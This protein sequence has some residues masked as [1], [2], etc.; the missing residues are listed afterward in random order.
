LLL[1]A[2]LAGL[3]TAPPG[4]GAVV[5][6]AGLIV[7]EAEHYQSNRT[8]SG[9]SWILTNDVAGFVGTGAMRALPSGSVSLST[10][11]NSPE[12]TYAVQFTN[13]GTLKIWL[14]VWGASGAHDSMYV[15][16]DGRNPQNL[17][18]GLTGVWVWKSVQ[19]TVT[20]GLHWINVWMREDGAYVDRLLIAR[21]ST[22]T[23]TNTG[24]AETRP[25]GATF[26]WASES[27]RIYVESGGSATLT[28]IKNALPKAPLCLIDA[29]NRIWF[30]DASL[31]VSDGAK[32]VLHGSAAGGDVNE[33]RLRS[34]NST[35][36]GSCASLDADWGTLDLKGV[37][38]TS[39]DQLSVGPDTDY[40]NFNR[41]CIRARSRSTSE[42]ST[43][44][45]VNC[46]IAFLGTDSSDNYGL[47]WQV[48]GTAP[49]ATV[50]GGVSNSY[51]HNCRLGLESTLQSDIPWQAN[52]I[53]SNTFFGFDPTGGSTTGGNSFAVAYRYA[54]SSDRI[55]VTGP[56]NA[57][58]SDIKTAVPSAPLVL[59]DPVNKVWRLDTD[60][61][62]ENGARLKL[63]GPAIGG[64]VRE[65]RLKS[66]ST[67]ATNA[68]VE[69][70]ADWGWLDIRNTKI[71]SWDSRTNGPNTRTNFGRAFIHA[72][73]RLDPDGHTAHESR[74]DVL[75]SEIA[76][77]G[78]HATEAY[79]LTWKVVD[80]TAIYVPPGSGKTLFD[81]VNVYGDIM[82]SHIHHNFFGV[83]SYGHFGGHWAT[84]EVDHNFAYGF[85]PHDDS[86]NLVIENNHVHH[87]GWHGI[88]ASK[89]CDHGI[90]RNNITHDNGLDRTNPHG[91]GIML[92]RSSND[93]LV[94][95][96]QSYNNPDSGVA[97]FASDRTI[98]RNNLCR[99]N[100]NAGIR[101]SVGSDNNRV[102]GNQVLN[103]G[104]NGFFM[105]E[106][107]DPPEIDEGELLPSARCQQN[108]FTNNFVNVY[109]REAVKVQNA[110]L[111]VFAGNVFI[112]TA[113]I[114]RFE[115]ST[116]NAVAS[117]VLPSDTLA[118]LV[119][120]ITNTSPKF[121]S[122]TF[123]GQPRLILQVDPL[124]TGRFTDKSGAMFISILTN[125]PTFIYPTG[126]VA[127][128]TSAKV[129][130]GPGLVL[131]RNFFG[132]PNTGSAQI[133]IN[134]WNTGGN[135]RTKAWTVR[136][137]SAT[138]QITYRVGDLRP[139]TV[140]DVRRN[141]ARVLNVR[142]DGQGYI[143]FTSSPGATTPVNY[144]VQ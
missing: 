53:A 35:A 103:S 78:H 144:T 39:W 106:G 8:A 40:A 117:N 132:V 15:G 90:L 68:Y 71:T 3:S 102:E 7:M 44:S 23:P 140:Y 2:A 57:T 84:N 81:L 116:N 93:W 113:T 112:G 96:N 72:R 135:N 105:F 126:S 136:A 109:G 22:Y 67:R 125:V 75:N 30:L 77:L 61:F 33:L 32:L 63:Y 104:G 89:R 85:D 9:H 16:V 92:H 100:L 87:N 143:S 131:T 58:L 64:D 50:F 20:N 123:A 69:L 127:T 118:K 121:T 82:N 111:N 56:G 80:T 4:V 66:E 110:D 94:E 115:G 55:Y 31:T 73:S 21:S 14:R 139:N 52:N 86:D 47:T 29:T 91:N 24:P 122:T 43:L 108:T 17:S 60:M 54:G 97:I 79:G 45:V 88:I 5:E 51:V 120:S 48:V 133:N 6:T 129:G 95:N 124:S 130:T 42:Q 13:A 34:D 65:L 70:R 1:A 28:D 99:S 38:V 83:Y 59:V 12:L 37:K 49:G 10:V 134:T 138:L 101:L 41:A 141:S 46:E 11:T 18:F 26:R 25:A 114:L 119:G 19:V 128:L 36:E 98:I 137:S 76:Y 107:T 142:A 27:S 74:M 62:V